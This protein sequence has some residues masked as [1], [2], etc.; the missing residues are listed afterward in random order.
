MLWCLNKRKQPL[1]YNLSFHRMPDWSQRQQMKRPAVHSTTWIFELRNKDLALVKLG[2]EFTKTQDTQP[3]PRCD[4][5]HNMTQD[6]GSGSRKAVLCSAGFMNN[7]RVSMA[8]RS[9]SHT[10]TC[11]PTSHMWHAS[12]C[13]RSCGSTASLFFNKETLPV[14]CH[15]LNQQ[16]NVQNE[17]Q[18]TI[19]GG[20]LSTWS[21]SHQQLGWSQCVRVCVCVCVCVC[22]TLSVLNGGAHT[23]EYPGVR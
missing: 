12:R 22:V 6:G 11:L 4:D 3:P 7:E 10:P 8:D 20:L 21:H 2:V 17:C 15:F 9:S 16:L 13:S 23:S 18:T 5:N 19:W 1:K 14:V